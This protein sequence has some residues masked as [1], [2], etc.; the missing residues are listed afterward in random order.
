MDKEQEYIIEDL[1]KSTDELMEDIPIEEIELQKSS[2]TKKKIESEAQK[3]EI[4]SLMLE[5]QPV[6]DG[7]VEIR[8]SNDDMEVTGNFY[9]SSGDGHPID[10]ED[11]RDKLKSFNVVFGIDW[12][13]IKETIDRCNN[14]LVQ[15][16]DVVIAR[17]ERPEDE[18]PEQLMIEERLLKQPEITKDAKSR[19]NYR[20]ITSYTLVNKGDTLARVAPKKEGKLGKSVKGELIPYKKPPIAQKK[21]GQN[22]KLDGDRVVA[23]KDGRFEL[24][25]NNFWVHE[26][27]EVTGDVDYHTGNI[28]FPGDIIIHGRVNDGFK[29]EA[30]GSIVCMETLDAS[31]VICKRNLEVYR[32][33]IGRQKGKISVGGTIHTKYIEN[34]YVEADDSIFVETGILHSI[35]RT[36]NTL[37]LLPKSIIA[38]GKIYA[39]NGIKAGQLGTKIGIKTEIYC[40]ID[41]KVQQN[42]EW[43]KDKTVALTAKLGLI[44]GRLKSKEAGNETL[45]KTKARIKE[46]IHKLNGVAKSLVLQID[47]NRKADVAIDGTVFPGVYIEI[48]NAP[49]IIPHEMSN[50]RFF[51]DQQ[52]GKVDY[53][54]L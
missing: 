18:I 23:T 43:I 26:V 50:I 6:V 35:V 2:E 15:I 42:L 51:L 49:Y 3:K 9:P 20:E 1:I 38:G 33:I 16:N 48:C 30:E 29:V 10:E 24:W 36:Q 54:I 17:G 21:Q 22:T 47:K 8:V 31:E 5:A 7:F 39:Q 12:K 14:E 34:C 45:L 46:Y 25:K 19:V 41:H 13:T 40:G 11:V 37:E 53:E 44:E 28:Q 32:G 27:F 52:Q 4:E